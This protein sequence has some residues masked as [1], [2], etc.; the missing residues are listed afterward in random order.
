MEFTSE[1]ISIEGTSK[2]E[3]TSLLD[4]TEAEATV[5]ETEDGVFVR[6][7]SDDETERELVKMSVEVLEKPTLTA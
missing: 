2:D 1:G 4:A 3:V 7:D 5:S 6:Y